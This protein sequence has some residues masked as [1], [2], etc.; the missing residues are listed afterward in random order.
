MKK[1]VINFIWV[2]VGVMIYNIIDYLIGMYFFSREDDYLRHHGILGFL[3]EIVV[4][5]FIIL[6]MRVLWKEF[7][8]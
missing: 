2:A 8:K 5:Y 6:I 1:H 7:R 4:V 3:I